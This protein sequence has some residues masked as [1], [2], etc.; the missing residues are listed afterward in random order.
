MKLSEKELDYLE[1]HIPEL[2]AA[3]VTQAYWTALA[4]G[5]SVLE[6]DDG[7]LIEVFPDGTRKFIENLP[8]HTK[9]ISGSVYKLNKND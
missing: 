7:K 2:A 1:S 8:P 5:H 6:A 3:A 9:V 4:S